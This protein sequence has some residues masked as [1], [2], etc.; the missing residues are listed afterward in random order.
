MEKADH[1]PTLATSISTS[2]DGKRRFAVIGRWSQTFFYITRAQ[3]YLS[4]LGKGFKGR[5]CYVGKE[6]FLKANS[7]YRF[8]PPGGVLL[9]RKFIRLVE[10]GILNLWTDEVNKIAAARK[11]QHRCR[12]KSSV[13]IFK[14]SQPPMPLEIE[15]KILNA[16]VLW[17]TCLTGCFFCIVVEIFSMRFRKTRNIIVVGMYLP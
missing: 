7:Y 2:K 14:E 1:I 15:G 4:K 6:L 13:E 16:F 3:D 5:A 12:I 8:T 17:A 9:S 11:V 10:A